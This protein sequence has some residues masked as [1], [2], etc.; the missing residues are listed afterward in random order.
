[1]LFSRHLKVIY[2]NEEKLKYCL[3]D[4][5][6]DLSIHVH[7]IITGEKVSRRLHENIC[8]D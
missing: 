7:F 6:N 3:C 1:M 4:Q 2:S 8:K 5:E